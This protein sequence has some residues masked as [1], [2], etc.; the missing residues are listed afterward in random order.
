MLVINNVTDFKI[1]K[2][3]LVSYILS[4]LWKR[5]Y[6]LICVDNKEMRYFDTENWFCFK[7][8]RII[9]IKKTADNIIIDQG[10]NEWVNNIT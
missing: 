8:L 4:T 9:I 10:R 5:S 7:T 6:R 3:K 2:K 1:N